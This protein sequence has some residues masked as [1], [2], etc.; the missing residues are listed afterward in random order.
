MDRQPA[1]GN[2]DIPDAKIAEWGRSRHEGYRKFKHSFIMPAPMFFTQDHHP[3][4]LMDTYR[5]RSV[6][7]VCGGPSLLTLDYARLKD[8]G[9]ITMGLNNSPPTVR[10]NLWCSVDSPDHWIRSIWLDPTI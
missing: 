7:L 5:G 8:P 9:I 1:G 2:K 3:L 4:P 6:F 10:P